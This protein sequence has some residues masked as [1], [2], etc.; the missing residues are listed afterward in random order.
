[1]NMYDMGLNNILI[2]EQINIHSTGWK[3]EKMKDNPYKI[4]KA[5]A[6]PFAKIEQCWPSN[7][8]NGQKQNVT[9]KSDTDTDFSGLENIYA[10]LHS[11]K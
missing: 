2:E 8:T 5:T 1:M 3:M 4:H 7:I 11:Q 9:Y 6:S 10:T